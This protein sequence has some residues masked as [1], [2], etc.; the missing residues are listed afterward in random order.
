[1]YGFFSSFTG[2][3][4]VLGSTYGFFSSFTGIGMEGG[5]IELVPPTSPIPEL[6]ENEETTCENPPVELDEDAN[7]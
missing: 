1:M 6:E 7:A 5:W 3:A 2:A 4:N